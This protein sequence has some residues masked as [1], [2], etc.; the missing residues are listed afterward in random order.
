MSFSI[1]IQLICIDTSISSISM[2]A[3]QKD[4]LSFILQDIGPESPAN[5]RIRTIRELADV[6]LKKKL[7]EVKNKI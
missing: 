1:S 4:I 2:T 7:E 6:V 3:L 5:N